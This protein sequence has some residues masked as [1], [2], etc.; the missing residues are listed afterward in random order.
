MTD[1]PTAPTASK[2]DLS[3]VQIWRCR[4]S[5]CKAWVRAE[6]AAGA[7]P[8]CPLCQGEMIRGIKH[9][10]KLVTKVKAQKKKADVVPW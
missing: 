10:P 6:L 5:S 3:P 2:P 7:K 8:S 9:L 1:V 4:S